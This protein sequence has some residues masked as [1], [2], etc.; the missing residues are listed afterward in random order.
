MFSDIPEIFDIV[1]SLLRRVTAGTVRLIALFNLTIPA[2]IGLKLNQ[3]RRTDLAFTCRRKA[4][5]FMYK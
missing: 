1:P 4:R 3:G 5:C 2:V